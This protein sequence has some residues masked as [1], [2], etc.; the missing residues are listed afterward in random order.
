MYEWTV[1]LNWST[2]R[3]MLQSQSLKKPQ[4]N[5]FQ[6]FSI[7]KFNTRTGLEV[8]TEQPAIHNYGIPISSAHSL[9]EEYQS[10]EDWMSRITA[11][12]NIMRPGF[13]TNK[14]KKKQCNKTR[15]RSNYAGNMFIGSQNSLTFP[16]CRNVGTAEGL[17]V[18]SLYSERTWT[19]F[20]H[21]YTSSLS[22]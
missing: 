4:D 22:C 17:D 16:V 6:M 15:T 10:L 13:K 19:C 18:F 1:Q 21:K 9:W 11:T 8:C 7:D 3:W 14:P 12:G 20:Y 5:H 2:C